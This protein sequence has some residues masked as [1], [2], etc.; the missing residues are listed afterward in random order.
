MHACWKLHVIWTWITQW[1]H[2]RQRHWSLEADLF[3]DA[4]DRL[5]NWANDWQLQISISKCSIMHIGTMK[6]NKTFFINNHALSC[7][8]L[9]KNLA[10]KVDNYL[11]PSPHVATIAVCCYCQP[12]SESNLSHV[13]F[14]WYSFVGSCFCNVCSAS[15]GNVTT[16][17]N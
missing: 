9:C 11:T 8:T 12:K 14:A 17:L 7:T 10:I 2:T 16:Y 5:S 15:C 3:Q 13:C 6:L 1:C 4:L